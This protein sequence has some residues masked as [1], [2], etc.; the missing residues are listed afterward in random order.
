M[1]I[2]VT[3]DSVTN[4]DLL[5]IKY[6]KTELATKERIPMVAV[7]LFALIGLKKPVILRIPNKLIIQLP[8]IVPITKSKYPLYAASKTVNIFGKEVPKATTV[9]LIMD[10]GIS[11]LLAMD[12]PPSTNIPAPLFSR[13]KPIKKSGIL[14]NKEMFCSCIHQ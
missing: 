6:N 13:K 9:K 14:S 1:E 4:N 3:T 11:S 8:I 2:S 5:A 10:S 7:F 12:V